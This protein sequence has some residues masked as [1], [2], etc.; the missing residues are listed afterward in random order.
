MHD[1]DS[2]FRQTPPDPEHPPLTP[3][4]ISN[5]D[6]LRATLQGRA[7][8]TLLGWYR[9][10]GSWTRLTVKALQDLDT[11]GKGLHETI[12]DLVLWRARQ[13]TQDQHIWIPPIE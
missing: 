3:A 1:L 13:H 4:T 5:P 2:P 9:L 7:L 11:P 8:D 12:V 6:L 10:Q